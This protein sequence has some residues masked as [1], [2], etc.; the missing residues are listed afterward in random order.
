MKNL[1]REYSNISLRN[2][3]EITAPTGQILTLVDN[4]NIREEEHKQRKK[5]RAIYSGGLT[6]GRR[7]GASKKSN[8][9]QRKSVANVV[10]D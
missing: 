10:A 6:G 8:G 1:W 4:I 3:L 2:A 9:K 7:A 5:S